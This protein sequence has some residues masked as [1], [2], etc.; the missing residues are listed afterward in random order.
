MN[1]IRMVLFLVCKSERFHQTKVRGMRLSVTKYQLVQLIRKK[2]TGNI[3]I[4]KSG[5][6][7]VDLYAETILARSRT[8]R[9]HEAHGWFQS[10]NMLTLEFKLVSKTISDI[11][12]IQ[13]AT[14]HGTQ[15]REGLNGTTQGTRMSGKAKLCKLIGQKRRSA[16][17]S[18][19][20]GRT[21][22]MT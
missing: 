17:S 8:D 14:I 11:T 2:L 4:S 15:N 1:R 20:W 9:R 22:Q 3:L 19:I 18:L 7:I 21:P 13:N 10:L 6:F 12:R 16:H 5:C